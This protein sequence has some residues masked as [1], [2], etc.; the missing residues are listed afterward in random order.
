MK[1]LFFI[2]LLF[3]GCG[4]KIPQHIQAVESSE[5][6]VMYI[7]AYAGDIKEFRLALGE[8]VLIYGKPAKRDLAVGVIGEAILNT[9]GWV[10]DGYEEEGSVRLYK[11][12]KK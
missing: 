9:K 7:E 5:D 2:A 6:A 1:K 12:K 3:F 4:E 8:E 10:F 11:F